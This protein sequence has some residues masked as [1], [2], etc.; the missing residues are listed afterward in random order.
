MSDRAPSAR[1]GGLRQVVDQPLVGLD[2]GQPLAGEDRPGTV[3]EQPFQAGA[4]PGLDPDL[5]VQREPSVVLPP[6]HQLRCLLRQHRATLEQLQHP[7]PG[8]LL[9]TGDGGLGQAG[10]VKP[11]TLLFRAEHAVDDATVEMQVGV[12]RG[13][14]AVDKRHRT[15]PRPARRVR[16]AEAQRRFDLGQEN[17]QHRIDQAGVT[18]KELAQPLR[19][20][21]HPLPHRHLG[22]HMIHPMRGGLGHAPGAAGGADPAALAREGDQE[23]MPAVRAA[24]PGEAVGQNAAGQVL[25]ELPLDVGGNGIAVRLATPREV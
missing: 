25:A 10:R 16:T 12:E 18:M 24:H 11:E 5:G 8:L 9:N 21:E 17:P 7:P 4:V 23:V 2:P 13:T 22:V 3:T 14:E 19:Q 1:R 6:E 20:R 15:E